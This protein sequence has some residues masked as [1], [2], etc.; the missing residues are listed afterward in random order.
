MAFFEQKNQTDHQTCYVF[1]QYCQANVK[2]AEKVKRAG[3]CS[4]GHTMV[5]SDYDGAAG[6]YET[7]WK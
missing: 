2:R 5:I 1:L 6:Q 7:G 4:N 3:E